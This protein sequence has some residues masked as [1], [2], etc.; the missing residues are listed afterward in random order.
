[1]IFNNIC[2][3]RDDR[4]CKGRSQGSSATVAVGGEVYSAFCRN[5]EGNNVMPACTRCCNFKSFDRDK[6]NFSITETA[7]GIK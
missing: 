4:T 6:M 1:M 2:D 7:G 3:I 5:P